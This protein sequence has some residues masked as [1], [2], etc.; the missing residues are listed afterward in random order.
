MVQGENTAVRHRY[1]HSNELNAGQHSRRWAPAVFQGR[2]V[3]EVRR[4]QVQ[5]CSQLHIQPQRG[6]VQARGHHA[7]LRSAQLSSAHQALEPCMNAAL[8]LSCCLGVLHALRHVNHSSSCQHTQQSAGNHAA[9]VALASKL[10]GIKA[11]IV[12]PSN[13]PQVKRDAVKTYGVDVIVCEPTIDAREQ[14][15][16]QLQAG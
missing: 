1:A 9:A 11:T 12:V 10:R 4:L 16:Q 14:T 3:S 8:P 5:G 7:Q 2:S 13:T 15:V 6:G